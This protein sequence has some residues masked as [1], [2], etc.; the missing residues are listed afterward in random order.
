MS[1]ARQKSFKLCAKE[2]DLEQNNL[3]EGKKERRMSSAKQ[4]SPSPCVRQQSDPEKKEDYLE[5]REKERWTCPVIGRSPSP[6]VRQQCAPKQKE[7][8][9]ET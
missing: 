5:E 1:S 8:T 6:S 2:D 7:D 3:K 4:R 9:L